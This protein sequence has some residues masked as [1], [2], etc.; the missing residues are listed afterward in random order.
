MFTAFLDANVLVPV[1][2]CD[3]MLRCAEADLYRPVWSEKVL[4]EARRAIHA[5][6]PDLS[7]SRIA[8]RFSNMNTAFPFSLIA[9]RHWEG[10]VPG[11]HVPDP[12]DRHVVAA[13]AA[14]GADVIVTANIRD[15]PIAEL[16][17]YSLERVD[18]GTFLRDMLDLNPEAVRH[19]LHMQIC[20]LR[21]PPMT[22]QMLLDRLLRANVAEFVA[23]YRSLYSD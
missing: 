16:A 6:H 8:S 17:E 23:D 7:E 11:I 18:P 9:K 15:F 22:I 10:M 19:A 4:D 12:N 2:L 13:A 1:H 14:A 20:N 5:I 21:R 3:T